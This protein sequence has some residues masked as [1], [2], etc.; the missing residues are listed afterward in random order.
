MKA[1]TNLYNKVD[2]QKVRPTLSFTEFVDLFKRSPQKVS[3]SIFQMFHDM[4]K[5][6]V[7]EGIN[8]YPN[9]PESIGFMHYDCTDLLV[10]GMD[11]PFLQIGYLLIVWCILQML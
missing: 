6:Y 7:G 10:Y 8:E 4:V 1:L 5:F 3:R 11:E 2:K 9:D